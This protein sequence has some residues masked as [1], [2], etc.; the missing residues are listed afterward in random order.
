MVERVKERRSK[1]RIETDLGAR[2]TTSEFGLEAIVKNMS[3]SGL[4]LETDKS[5]KEMTLVGLRLAL[6]P[7]GTRVP[8][9]AFEIQ[10]AI[11]RCAKIPKSRPAK[12]EVA[13]FMTGIPH[14]AKLALHDYIQGRLR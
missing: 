12:Y 11:V 3:E 7:Q 13:V 14:E 9:I 4:L 1:P 5:V 2:I 6:P 10:G 8:R